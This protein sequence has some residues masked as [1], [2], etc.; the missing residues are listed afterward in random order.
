MHWNSQ[1]TQ[2]KQTLTYAHWKATGRGREHV[3]NE[4]A[5]ERWNAWTEFRGVSAAN[6]SHFRFFLSFY[7]LF[8]STQCTTLLDRMRVRV[9]VR[10]IRLINAT[11]C[12]SACARIKNIRRTVIDIIEIERH[13]PYST[14]CIKRMHQKSYT[15][16]YTISLCVLTRATGFIYILSSTTPWRP[17][18]TCSA[19][20]CA[21]ACLAMRLYVCST[22]VDMAEL[23]HCWLL[24]SC[25][26]TSV[27]W[28]FGLA[29]D[30]ALS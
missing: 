24:H 5:R 7:S 11:R 19:L 27:H 20:L 14:Q 9:R 26:N 29:C 6:V 13:E 23:H 30:C 10:W 21:Y 22:Y 28:E 15:K 18:C 16:S 8:S 17:R 12:A 3:Q 1:M 4:R 2:S 25:T